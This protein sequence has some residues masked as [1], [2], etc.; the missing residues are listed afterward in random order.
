MRDGG[1]ALG[2]EG[3]KEKQTHFYHTIL[4]CDK[5]RYLAGLFA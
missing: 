2:R 1:R 5:C 4:V 3:L